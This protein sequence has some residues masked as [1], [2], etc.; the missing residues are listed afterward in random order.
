MVV[1]LARSQEE[2]VVR[3]KLVAQYLHCNR[4]EKPGEIL[5]NIFGAGWASGDVRAET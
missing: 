1:I 4:R 2:G 5:E 3:A